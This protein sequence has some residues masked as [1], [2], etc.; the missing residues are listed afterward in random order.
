MW[1]QVVARVSVGPGNSRQWARLV[2]GSVRK[3]GGS[4]LVWFW[5]R[6]MLESL[7][8]RHGRF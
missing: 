1:V 7:E 6:V 2:L 5:Q 4:E 8:R 3:V